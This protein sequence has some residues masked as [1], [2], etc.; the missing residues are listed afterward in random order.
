MKYFTSMIIFLMPFFLLAQQQG[1][2]V[3]L[4]K[5]EVLIKKNNKKPV[6]LMPRSR[7]SAGDVIIIQRDSVE[8]TIAKIDKEAEYLKVSKKGNYK[9]SDLFKT[10]SNRATG[11]MEKYFHFLWEHLIYP[12]K[13]LSK[14]NSSDLGS[15]GGV[16]RA[17]CSLGK[18]PYN[19]MV[20]SS[21]KIVFQWKH[22]KT[23]TEYKIKITDEE[24]N[25]L[26]QL[27]VR[28]TQVVINSRFFLKEQKSIFYWSVNT[29]NDLCKPAPEYKCIILSKEEYEKEIGEI[30]KTINE[31]EQ[32][33]YK[34]KAAELLKQKGFYEAAT[35]YLKKA[36][37]EKN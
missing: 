37:L 2:L 5:G 34:L 25:D 1:Y 16:V 17:G 4:I 30:L 23:E 12:G 20:L 19:D 35:E 24:K 18:F 21:E 32:T 8:V 13:D 3:D 22:V 26:I 6:R 28:D 27:S 10:S 36:V 33:A 14:L 31:S 9:L 15:W 7:L 29:L 11:I